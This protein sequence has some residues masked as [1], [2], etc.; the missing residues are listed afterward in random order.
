MSSYA[1]RMGIEKG[2]TS[3][4]STMTS[5]DQMSKKP[6]HSSTSTTSASAP[7][8][9]P[10]FDLTS[11]EPIVA[12][13]RTVGQATVKNVL[14]GDLI[15]VSGKANG[16]EKRI[17]ISGITAPKIASGKSG[18]DEPFAWQSREFLRGKLL[19]KKITF[20]SHTDAHADVKLNGEDVATMIVS[21]GLATVSLP[22]ATKEALEQSAKDAK[23]G[24]KSTESNDIRFGSAEKEALYLLQLAAE[25]KKVGMFSGASG[26]RVV[27]TEPDTM[28]YYKQY[29]NKPLPALVD[30]VLDGSTFRLL[31]PGLPTTQKTD[32]L[33]QSMLTVSLAG[34]L[35]PRLPMKDAP[36]DKK[37]PS[38]VYAMDSFLLSESRLANRDVSLIIQGLDKTGSIYGTVLHPKGNIAVRLLED[39][40]A[41]H[42]PWTAAL[43][44]SEDQK[45][46]REAVTKAADAG[47]RLYAA[48]SALAAA[49]A[50]PTVD[51]EATVVQVVSGDSLVVRGSDNK[52]TRVSLASIEAPRS[53]ASGS[54]PFAFEA[55][56]FLRKSLIG[57]KVRVVVEYERTFT[58]TPKKTTSKKTKDDVEVEADADV[59]AEIVE[60]EAEAEAE[61][62]T[63]SK[64]EEV[65]RR[66]YVTI[67]K[68][69]TN[70]A[71]EL[72]SAGLADV[73]TYASKDAQRSVHYAELCAAEMSA[74]AANKG[75]HSNVI[76]AVVVDLTAG[77]P[78]KTKSGTVAKTVK[79]K[80]EEKAIV[81]RVEKL[82]KKF[83][84]SSTRVQAVIDQV[85][86]PTRVKLYI[87]SE[88]VFVGFT[89]SGVYG[90]SA[91][92]KG[93][94]RSPVSTAAAKYLRSFLQQDVE[95]EVM[96]PS[97]S[98]DSLMGNV[99]S[100]PQRESISVGLLR[101]GLA[102]VMSYAAD[103]NSF[104]KAMLDAEAAAKKKRIAIWANFDEEKERADRERA[105]AEAVESVGFAGVYEKDGAQY[106]KIVITDVADGVHFYFNNIADKNV[107]LVAK[108]LSATDF[109]AT[110]APE[111]FETT[112]GTVVLA[113]F[114]DDSKWYRARIESFSKNTGLFT[115]QFIDYGN[116]AH[117]T[118][119]NLRPCPKELLSIKQLARPACLS[120]LKPPAVSS[121]HFEEAGNT[122]AAMTFGQE[123]EARIDAHE[124]RK[125]ANDIFHL[126]L[127]RADEARSVNEVLVAEGWARVSTRCL[128][129]LDFVLHAMEK[130]EMEAKNNRKNI[131]EYGSCSSDAEDNYNF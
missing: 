55:K 30:R 98:G 39:G 53:R 7:S 58:N 115:V 82:S 78:S 79:S 46:L 119:E 37:G 99:L 36:Q 50:A 56:E 9:S 110:P 61:S 94:P 91:S 125:G 109:S 26:T 83:T 33:S 25:K 8:K 107:E 113:L 28:A 51:Y 42:V 57:K 45:A 11:D 77:S 24:K 80:I 123:F 122:L 62:K 97:K 120:A 85:F 116:V 54:E 128:R 105:R 10:A 68:G 34:V 129:S 20:I 102:S 75:K 117:V 16:A 44:P 32:G 1:E 86:S 64:A 70:V 17:I 93:E 90:P 73:V 12:T 18:V 74:K 127:T 47:L 76:P 96:G 72:V 103:R 13:K 14:S 22:K 108:A 71:T 63:S 112:K 4:M 2:A 27:D 67:F 69:K 3:T 49:A 100:L 111:D 92:A 95:I 48:G 5:I 38:S 6:A 31:V 87:P 35:A 114:A 52:E 19:G 130:F 84:N 126:S 101:Q 59:E 121:E 89:L 104:K 21:Q 43:L 41:R 60:V 29:K 106:V 81:E 118:L 40:L 66:D 15:V 23:A 124:R 88:N 65:E 131:W